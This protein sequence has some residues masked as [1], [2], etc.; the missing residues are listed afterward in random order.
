MIDATLL[1]PKILERAGDNREMRETAAKIA[2]KRAAGEG[3]FPH[4]LPLRL[5]EK[6]L[7]VAVADGVWQKQLKAMSAELV[8]RVNKLLQR[9]VVETIEFRINPAA[10]TGVGSAKRPRRDA[11]SPTDLPAQVVFSAS[12][13]QDDELRQRFIRAAENCIARRDAVGRSPKSEI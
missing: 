2:W 11:H 3:L 7:I 4:A 12:Q 6:T 10:L 5:H 8:F 9:S 13:I 1:L